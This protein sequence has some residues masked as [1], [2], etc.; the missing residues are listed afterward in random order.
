MVKGCIDL[1]KAINSTS[2]RLIKKT[3]A[4]HRKKER[5]S[6]RLF[7]VEGIKSVNESII[8]N[9]NIEY[10]FYTESLFK[11]EDGKDLFYL[12]KNKSYNVYKVSEKVMKK[13]SDTKSPQGIF[14]VIKFGINEFKDILQ[15]EYNFLLLLDRVQDPGNMGTIIRTADALG[16]NGI[17]ITEGCVDIYNPKT[18]RSTMGSIFHISLSFCK[19]VFEAIDMLKENNIKIIASSLETENYCYELNY[20]DPFALVI[21]NEANGI[22]EKIIRKSDFKVKIPMIGNA[23]SLNAGV[24]AG[25]LMYEASRQIQN[26]QTN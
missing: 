5:W 2:N 24:A 22:C 23:E 4:L 26:I 8:W 13:I 7:F 16:V 20:K 18:I 17:I 21:G 6:N 12:I 14:A 19:N 25:I 11:T 15:H 9:T 3:K 10:I 1:E